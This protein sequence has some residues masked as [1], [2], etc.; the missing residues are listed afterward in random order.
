MGTFITA[1]GCIGGARGVTA[2]CSPPAAPLL[3]TY[4]RQSKNPKA[5][6][7]LHQGRDCHATGAHSSI[8]NLGYPRAWMT[9]QGFYQQ[10]NSYQ[11]QK[12]KKMQK[13]DGELPKKHFRQ[14]IHFPEEKRGRVNLTSKKQTNKQ[15]HIVSGV[16]L[17]GFV[18]Q[19]LWAHTSK[20]T[21]V[22][23][24]YPGAH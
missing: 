4:S 8:W 16:Q 17:K 2:Q 18:N 13:T 10:N 19:V 1:P 15:T 14:S 23:S 11:V 12:G 21:N 5:A 7:G 9:E 6:E 20:Y 24:D 22:L 3:C